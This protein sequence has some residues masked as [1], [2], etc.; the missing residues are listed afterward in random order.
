MPDGCEIYRALIVSFQNGGNQ[1]PGDAQ[2]I[3]SGTLE[4]FVTAAIENPE[5]VTAFYTQFWGNSCEQIYEGYEI[6]SSELV[7]IA[8]WPNPVE[9]VVFQRCY[10][11]IPNS[12]GTIAVG[13]THIASFQVVPA[14][15]TDD[16][17]VCDCMC[18]CESS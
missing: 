9:L 6:E 7:A 13:H 10:L 4:I 12:G 16:G 2:I 14:P 15:P 11:I 17:C 18:E 8:S 3:E 5:C 1:N